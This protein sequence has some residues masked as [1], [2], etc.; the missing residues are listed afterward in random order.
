MN[1]VSN[2]TGMTSRTSKIPGV[3]R[4][5]PAFALAVILL[6]VGVAQGQNSDR[7]KQ[8]GGKLICMCNCG[9]ILTACNHVGCTMS[10]A[11]LKKMDQRVEANESDD[12]LLQSFVQEYGEQV[13][14]EPPTHGFNSL[15]WAIPGIAFALGLG[16]VVM[17]IRHWRNRMTLAPA[18]GPAI[19]PEMMERVRHQADVETDD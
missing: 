1:S 16:L 18:A 17:V 2:K 3:L 6:S 11:M 9:Q 19:S 8:L 15:A 13:L 4:F 14:A 7:A 5:A 12:L 10:A